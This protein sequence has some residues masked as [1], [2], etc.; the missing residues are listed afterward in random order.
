[1][2]FS[3]WQLKHFQIF[4]IHSNFMYRKTTDF[5]QILSQRKKKH[6]TT[7][8]VIQVNMQQICQSKKKKGLVSKFKIKSSSAC[9]RAMFTVGNEDTQC[10]PDC[11]STKS[12]PLTWSI[13]ACG[14]CTNMDAFSFGEDSRQSWA[15]VALALYE[16]AILLASF[17]SYRTCLWCS[18]K[19]ISLSDLN[20]KVLCK[21]KAS[22]I[23][24]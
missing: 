22:L 12:H 13:N 4:F 5:I 10:R 20:L 1:M 16:K 3:S 2:G 21:S 15:S 18:A 8:L 17:P 14:E 24:L 7:E 11:R 6:M 23:L 19:W 9:R